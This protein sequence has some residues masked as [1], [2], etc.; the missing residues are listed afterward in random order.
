[1][2]NL[3][4][5]FTGLLFDA[6]VGVREKTGL[7]QY[8]QPCTFHLSKGPHVGKHEQNQMELLQKKKYK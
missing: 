1:M 6:Y 8:Y 3:A 2:T 5:M 7:W 4:Q